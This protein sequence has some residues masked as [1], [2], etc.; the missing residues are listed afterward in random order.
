MP[1]EMSTLQQLLQPKFWFVATRL[2]SSITS[3]PFCSLWPCNGPT[4]DTNRLSTVQVVLNK[5][6]EAVLCMQRRD[7]AAATGMLLFRS[8]PVA[9]FHWPHAISPFHNTSTQSFITMTNTL[10]QPFQSTSTWRF[11]HE[12]VLTV[13]YYGLRFRGSLVT[14]TIWRLSQTRT[15]RSGF[16]VLRVCCS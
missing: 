3:Q 15:F 9:C 10:P 8:L 7:F 14:L 4:M 13:Q 16:H 6:S 1:H 5:N 2:V 11:F 12:N